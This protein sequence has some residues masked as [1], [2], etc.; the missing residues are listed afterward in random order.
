MKEISKLKEL[1]KEATSQDYAV[2]K[3]IKSLE[4]NV[5]RIETTGNKPID[6][7][8]LANLKIKKAQE[9]EATNKRIKAQAKLL[10]PVNASVEEPSTLVHDDS[11]VPVKKDGVTVIKFGSKHDSTD[12]EQL[13]PSVKAPD[14]AIDPGF[15]GPANDLKQ[16]PV[17]TIQPMMDMN[18]NN[19]EENNMEKKNVIIAIE[20]SMKDLFK[21][22]KE[23]D[24]EEP[25]VGMM[26]AVES[27]AEEAEMPAEE[28]SE[29]EEV[30][31]EETVEVDAD[32][33]PE[34][35]VT[36]T[37]IKIEIPVSG[38]EEVASE[39][40]EESA[41]AL[42]EAFRVVYGILSGKPLNEEESV[43]VPMDAEA[44]V[45]VEE[46]KIVIEI[47]VGQKPIDEIS[48]EQNEKLQ[49]ALSVISYIL[50]EELGD[51]AAEP[52]HTEEKPEEHT[53]EVD[54]EDI[55]VGQHAE[56][57]EEVIVERT[58]SPLEKKL[59]FGDKG[60]IKAMKKGVDVLGQNA[61]A[62]AAKANRFRG[63]AKKVEETG[64]NPDTS[65]LTSKKSKVVDSWNK[66]AATQDGK[67]EEYQQASGIRFMESEETVEV[68]TDVKP[69]V[70]VSSDT[71][72]IEIPVDGKELSSGLSDEKM[73]QVQESLRRIHA[74][75]ST[76]LNEEESVE[77]PMDAEAEV[78]VEGDVLVI[79]IPLEEPKEMVSSDES[80]E[81]DS[82]IQ[83]ISEALLGDAAAEPVHDEKA[84]EAHTPEV[85]NEDILDGQHAEEVEE[86]IV[87]GNEE[88]QEDQ[89]LDDK[90][91]LVDVKDKVVPVVKAG[92]IVISDHDH[93]DAE[94]QEVRKELIQE[95]RK[96]PE[97]LKKNTFDK[98]GD[99]NTIPEKLEP[100]VKAK[101]KLKEELG[102]A[103][104]EPVHGTEQPK[105]HTPEVENKDILVGQHA[106]E[107][108][109]VIVE[110]AK[111]KLMTS[112][113]K[114][115]KKAK[116]PE[117]KGSY[118]SVNSSFDFDTDAALYL[119]KEF[120]LPKAKKVQIVSETAAQL[121]VEDTRALIEASGFTLTP[122]GFK[123]FLKE[124]KAS[125]SEEEENHLF[126]EIN[127][128]KVSKEFN[129]SLGDSKSELKAVIVES[130]LGSAAAEPVATS[131]APAKEHTPEVENKD[132]LVGQ[133]A[134][135]VKEVV[136]EG[137]SP[138]LKDL[139][140]KEG[141][142]SEI[143][144]IGKAKL[145][146]LFSR[147]YRNT[148][149]S[150]EAKGKTQDD[151]GTK[152]SDYKKNI[153]RKDKGNEEIK[154]ATGI[155]FTES[156]TKLPEP[157]D[158]V[159]NQ[160]DIEAA[161]KVA[162]NPVKAEKQ[163]EIVSNKAENKAQP[164][165]V[166]EA[167]RYKSLKEAFLLEADYFEK[168]SFAKVTPE[169][170]IEKLIEQVALLVS[171][172]KNDPLYEELIKTT[173]LTVKLQEELT[174]KY[175]SFANKKAFEMLSL[176]SG[177]TVQESQ[178]LLEFFLIL[179]NTKV[180]NLNE[181]LLSGLRTKIVLFSVR[182]LSLA[183][184]DKA[185]MTALNKG[186]SLVKTPEEKQKL[187][188]KFAPAIQSKDKKVKIQLIREV[189]K[190]APAEKIEQAGGAIVAQSKKLQSTAAPAQG[191]PVAESFD[192][193]LFE[194]ILNEDELQAGFD[195]QAADAA[196]G[197]V[198]TTYG[199]IDSR[200]ATKVGE[201]TA[202]LL[203]QMAK[204]G[205]L[206]LGMAGP[207]SFLVGIIV[208]LVG[209]AIVYLIKKS[210]D[211]KAAESGY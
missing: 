31:S 77:V 109:E 129:N 146:D 35:T 158:A 108:E 153:E 68:A 203:N 175:G 17:P 24:S 197:V 25:I 47:P 48:E 166:T 147:D 56:E 30:K 90:G 121:F 55:L 201:A 75:F 19:K 187:D 192:V 73:E 54:N 15:D 11:I 190:N 139:M 1:L 162:M 78:K 91:Q 23:E 27:P 45:K 49:E 85:D 65:P 100:F 135:E 12:K 167:V 81:I 26:P 6:P 14:P 20:E 131:D 86:V 95:K 133:H 62:S 170:K 51:A 39:V 52:V 177:M 125:L 96:L 118:A 200:V 159:D 119:L 41:E 130:E 82:E 10:K 140:K 44:D 164:E 99:G 16:V 204:M 111:A 138:L 211:A 40:S 46:D 74:I 124:Q 60:E 76:R 207:Q 2:N 189:L 84:P 61:E 208:A 67:A 64:L 151:G 107:V 9:S 202:P 104:A 152:V 110:S 72:R 210:I 120:K 4:E 97:A 156:E 141:V 3:V 116:N 183:N 196:A 136:V 21:I 165:D 42:K 174:A 33:Q 193:S 112:K 37:S 128:V 13:E 58:V 176:K 181:G 94:G 194:S 93:A 69:E 163:A 18:I 180:E 88:H 143:Q 154:Q 148:V 184:L 87:E 66:K 142:K 191:Q 70:M 173:A 132:I 105:E 38:S 205:P 113:K 43:E 199:A 71:I 101:T 206:F 117:V 134:E 8:A 28:P 144:L 160:Y 179:G 188:A 115:V 79:E 36:D 137:K 185:L 53:P 145:N 127:G 186:K 114:L 106:E 34:V 59:V 50:K 195:K 102:S 92:E 155:K 171:R 63:Y 178:E 157:S 22:L 161:N 32:V 83:K 29:M 198:T 149:K 89:M 57:V 150:L 209:V 123:K 169:E 5:E 126:K 168:E 7:V 98:K 182:F 172:E 80:E 103:A 122:A